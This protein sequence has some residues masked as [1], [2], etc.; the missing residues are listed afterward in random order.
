MKPNDEFDL[1]PDLSNPKK[2]LPKQ[3]DFNPPSDTNDPISYSTD[4]GMTVEE[5]RDPNRI[6]V[7]ISD[8]SPIIILFGAR[9][10]GKTMTLVRLTRYLKKNGYKV[11][12]D[13]IFRPSNSAHYEKM[14]NEFDR[15]INNNDLS[16]AGTNIISFML[17]KVMN[18]NGEPVCQILEA[19]GEHYFDP[20]DIHKPFPRYINE[21]C[22]I[23]NPKTWIFIVERS[24]SD[25]NTRL[26]YANKII[27]M[28]S[29]IDVRDKII[30]MCHK[31]DLHKSLI[32]KDSPNDHQFFKD[33]NNQY[34]GIFDKYTNKIP[35]L[36][37]FNRYS[38]DFVTFS[39]GMFNKLASVGAETFTPSKDKY[40]HKLWSVILKTVKGSWF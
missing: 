10:S 14:C 8:P 24:W 15:N 22:S 20:I 25:S 33:I 23:D 30:F 40:P 27:E 12:P 31:V 34:P 29:Q 32:I 26:A 36:N 9:T 6:Q 19:P 21:I 16:G 13:R 39:A 1:T 17:V 4:S 37:W 18:A 7:V 28:E 38:F 2:D 5:E 11:E 3:N 35:V